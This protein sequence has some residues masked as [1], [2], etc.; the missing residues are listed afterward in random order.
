MLTP[1]EAGRELDLAAEKTP[2]PWVRHSISV[3]DNAGLIAVKIN[4]MDSERAY[5]MG[6]LHDIGRREGF[7]AVMPYPCRGLLEIKN[8]NYLAVLF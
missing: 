2:G 3:A 8:T 6:L 1:E 4:G 7:K 5:V